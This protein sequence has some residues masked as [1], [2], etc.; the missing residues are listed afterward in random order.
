MPTNGIADNILYSINGAPIFTYGM[1]SITAII[2]AY[3]TFIETPDV[4]NENPLETETKPIESP[5][6]NEQPLLQQFIPDTPQEMNLPVTTES[7]IL[8]GSI[9]N[10]EVAQS[11]Q[12]QPAQVEPPVQA[13]QLQETVP[14]EVANNPVTQPSSETPIKQAGKKKQS[15]KNKPN[16]SKT[17]KRK[18]RTTHT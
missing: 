12:S 6:P 7:P 4:P 14:Q 11:V 13:E 10:E 18:T 16:I 17:T 9:P 1:I 5:I 15:R 8:Q 2:L 3:V